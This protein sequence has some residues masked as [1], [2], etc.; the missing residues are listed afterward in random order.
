MREILFRGKGK[1]NNKEWVYGNLIKTKNDKFWI[2]NNSYSNGGWLVLTRRI[3]IEKETLGQFTGL[4]DKNGNKI[5]EGDIVKSKYNQITE[6]K[7]GEFSD[8]KC[9]EQVGF[10]QVYREEDDDWDGALHGTMDYVK[11][12]EIIGNIHDNGDLY[13]KIKGE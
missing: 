6:I 1:Y 11:D 2:T 10:Y 8:T 7:F 3:E 4:L 13:R 12:S 9:H 5:F